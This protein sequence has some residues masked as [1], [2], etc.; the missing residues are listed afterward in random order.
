MQMVV[1]CLQAAVI[2]AAKAASSET[3]LARGDRVDR[4][5]GRSK[6]YRA[7]DSHA[8]TAARKKSLSVRLSERD[9]R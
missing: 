4:Q 3:P 2:E 1:L 6:A 8:V 7:P 9:A 5:P